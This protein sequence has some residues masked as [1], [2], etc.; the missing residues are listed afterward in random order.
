M[1]EI[2]RRTDKGKMF[3][4]VSPVSPPRFEGAP[5]RKGEI[6]K[7]IRTDNHLH[8]KGGGKHEKHA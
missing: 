7:I 2:E 8:E 1:K 3:F 5:Y 4:N 6:K